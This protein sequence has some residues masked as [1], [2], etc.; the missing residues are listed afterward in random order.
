MG[1]AVVACG[2]SKQESTASEEAAVEAPQV[3]EIIAGKELT[4]KQIQFVPEDW[5]HHGSR[6]L[7]PDQVGGE[8]YWNALKDWLAKL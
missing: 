2:P 1:A 8:E 5:G 3:E 7:W 6:A 4:D